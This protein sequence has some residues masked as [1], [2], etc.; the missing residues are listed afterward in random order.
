[1]EI[2]VCIKQVQDP[3]IPPRDF[4]VDEEKLAVIPPAN[5]PPVIN[6]FDE[7]AIEAAIQLKEAHG[8]KVTVLTVGTDKARDALKKCLAMGCDEAILLQD[9]AFE[10][11]D[12]FGVAR[13]LAGAVRKVGAFDLILCGRLSSDWS[14]GATPLALA[15]ALELPSVGQLQK[16]EATASGLRCERALEEG[17]EV[18]DVSTP[19]LLTVSNEMNTPRLPSV[20]GILM[21]SRK[22]IPVWSAADVGVDPASV[23]A[24]AATLELTKLY[25][26]VFSGTCEFIEG[27]TLEEA[28]EKLA[29]RLREDKII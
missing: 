19:C 15:E 1:V 27:E 3:D 26:P 6:G 23:G 9:P 20:K 2:L 28:A 17:V 12:A 10:G 7:N 14:Y 18:V 11:S 21:A 8:G 22:Q 13:L 5:V 25:K 16:V 24:G 29:L 4:K